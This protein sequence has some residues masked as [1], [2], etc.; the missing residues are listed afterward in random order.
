MDPVTQGA[1]GAVVAQGLA[2]RRKLAAIACYGAVA[3][4]APDLDVLIQSPDD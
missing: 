4:M 2:G 3:G 1:L